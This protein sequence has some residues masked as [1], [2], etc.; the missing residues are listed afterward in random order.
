MD[1]VGFADTYADLTERSELSK[2]S[3]CASQA[4]MLQEQARQLDHRIPAPPRVTI[5]QGNFLGD[6]IFD[7]RWSDYKFHK[8][9]QAS[10]AQARDA[11]LQV[12]SMATHVSNQCQA[13]KQEAV[14]A[15][16]AVRDA[17]AV[18]QGIRQS[19]IESAAPGGSDTR[20]NQGAAGGAAP[21]AVP[22]GLPGA[23]QH[24]D[25]KPAALI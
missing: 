13:T 15:D 20:P 16:G 19:I 22:W 6:V 8:K 12:Q 2:A 14:A 18:L 9:I 7:S 24:G 4:S 21:M 17:R 23:Q 11:L 3:Q 10:A 1:I 5:A 25:A